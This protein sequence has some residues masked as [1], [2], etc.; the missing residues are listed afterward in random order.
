MRFIPRNVVALLVAEGG[1]GKTFFGLDLLDGG[2][3]GQLIPRTR[4]APL[5]SCTCTENAPTSCAAGNALYHRRARSMPKHEVKRFADNVRKNFALGSFVGHQLHLVGLSHGVAVQTPTLE[6]LTA[7]LRELSPEL[8]VLDPM[9][10]LHGADENANAMGTA[11][12]DAAERIA[13]ETGATVLISHHTGKGNANSRRTRTPTQRA[14]HPALR[15]QR[16]SCWCCE[17]STTK[18]ARR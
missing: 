16:A 9:S 2:S 10:R 12:I 3:L 4:H 8:I 11:I 18:S 14:E 15:T 7:R 1:V 13:R 17:R 5:Q 6:A